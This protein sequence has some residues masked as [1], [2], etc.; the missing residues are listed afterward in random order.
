LCTEGRAYEARAG[1][2]PAPHEID[3]RPAAVRRCILGGGAQSW[4]LSIGRNALLWRAFPASAVFENL[5]AGATIGEVMDWFHLTREQVAA[6]LKFTARSLDTPPVVQSPA[7]QM[8]DA[9]TFR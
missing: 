6:V 9:H 5:E 7:A 4:H 3:I 1:F 2:E 8:S